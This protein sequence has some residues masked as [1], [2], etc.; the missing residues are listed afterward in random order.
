VSE[1]PRYAELPDGFAWDLLD[2]RLGSLELLTPERVAA[3]AALV[4][5]GRRF[6]L[7]LPLD[8]PDPPMFG[9]QAMRHEVF[10]LLPGF[11]LDDKLDNF[12]PQAST[13]WDAFSHYAHTERGFFGGTDIATAKAGRLGIDA[14]ARV[15]IVGRGVLLDV[16]RHAAATGAPHALDEDTLI[17]P[18]QLE[19]VAAWAGVELRTGDILCVRT[20]W[21]GYYRGLDAD[22]RAALSEASTDYTF[23]DFRIPGLGRGPAVAEF[24]WDHGV[25]AV[26]V[27]NP[28]VEPFG[29]SMM[30]GGGL[31]ESLHTRVLAMLG[32]PLGEF[33]D[34]DALA[35]DC[36]GDGRWDFLFTSAPLTI[37]GGVGSPPNALAIK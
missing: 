11:V 13:Q 35:D 30:E 12:Y 5:S 17:T 8:L 21:V 1:R 32:I 9:R 29:P 22:R 2:P 25:A 27:D 10:E 36:E 37:P 28:G 6:S 34:F 23:K 19:A 24:L 7:N 18:D 20:G 4:Q 14:W 31:D 26:A 16:P 15:G 3:A 33:F